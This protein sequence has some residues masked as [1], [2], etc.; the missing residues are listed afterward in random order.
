MDTV[1]KLHHNEPPGDV[2]AFLTGMVSKLET[3][4]CKQTRDLFEPSCD[5]KQFRFPTRSDTNQVVRPQKIV[6]SLKFGFKKKRN[7]TTHVAKIKVLI[8]C[9]VIAQLIL[10]LCFRIYRLLVF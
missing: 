7:C 5:K 1:I 4:G 6:K 9:A 10:P 3:R 2:L 8:S